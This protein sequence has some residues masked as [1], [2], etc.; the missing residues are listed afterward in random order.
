MSETVFRTGHKSRVRWDK[1]G[2]KKNLYTHASIFIWFMDT[3]KLENCVLLLNWMYV[4]YKKEIKTIHNGQ[5]IR[6][7]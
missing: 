4:L 6:N 3:L 5:D 7:I 2:L 1:F